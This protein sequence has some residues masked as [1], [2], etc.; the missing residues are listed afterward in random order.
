MVRRTIPIIERTQKRGKSNLFL[1]FMRI[2]V[3]IQYLHGIIGMERYRAWRSF[4]LPLRDSTGLSPDF[5]RI[6]PVY[7]NKNTI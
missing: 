6:H 2:L 7:K 4:S 5:P 3:N 1:D